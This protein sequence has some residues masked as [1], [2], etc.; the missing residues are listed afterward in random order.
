MRLAETHY[1]AI[2]RTLFNAETPG[3]LHVDN[4]KGVGGE[5]WY[6]SRVEN[7]IFRAS[8]TSVTR[9]SF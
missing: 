5:L 9:R 1:N 6:S 4:L 2:L 8:S 7:G 3:A